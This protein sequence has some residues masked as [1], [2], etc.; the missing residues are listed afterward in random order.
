MKVAFALL[1]VLAAQA[2]ADPLLITW[3][4]ET[5]ASSLDEAA[6]EALPIALEPV[7]GPGHHGEHMP[8]SGGSGPSRLG[9]LLH[10]LGLVSTTDNMRD[11]VDEVVHDSPSAVR[12]SSLSHWR[13]H[14][15]ALMHQAQDRMIPLLE[16]GGIKL[17]PLQPLDHQPIEPDSPFDR[18][19][20]GTDDRTPEIKWWR[21]VGR[22]RWLVNEGA[23]EWREPR[24]D[25][26]A[27]RRGRPTVRVESAELAMTAPESPHS[28]MRDGARHHKIAKTAAGRL[29]R[30]LKNLKPHESFVVAWIIG[31]GLGSI[32]HCLFMVCLLVFRRF[33]K[34]TGTCT[35]IRQDKKARRAARKAERKAKRAERKTRACGAIRLAGEDLFPGQEALPAYTDEPGAK[36]K[37]KEQV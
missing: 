5:P 21:A 28:H 25:E 20:R 1:A 24:P 12:S 31:A 17:L 13:E 26:V 8:C 4:D 35:S 36:L 9:A 32:I 18:L 19:M 34:R 11:S 7:P 14:V 30:A 29:H 27:P 6:F 37:E 22:G 16:G 3:H 10:K 15:K 23:G 33:T 2:T